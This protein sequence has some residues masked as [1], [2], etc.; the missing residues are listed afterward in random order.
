MLR[1]SIDFGILNC[2]EG[3]RPLRICYGIDDIS[4]EALEQVAARGWVLTKSG[5]LWNRSPEAYQ[6]PAN[7]CVLEKACSLLCVPCWCSS[8]R[9]VVL[10]LAFI[11]PM[12]T[13]RNLGLR[14]C[15]DQF[16]VYSQMPPQQDTQNSQPGTTIAN[17]S[18]EPRTPLTII[19]GYLN[20]LKSY[21]THLFQEDEKADVLRD[22]G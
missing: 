17:V 13:A 2:R 12:Y 11:D 3:S 20:I 10:R 16:A 1:F 19:Y 7:A 15:A 14:F 21:P 9:W 4:E 18:H 22:D 5:L 8:F 6:N